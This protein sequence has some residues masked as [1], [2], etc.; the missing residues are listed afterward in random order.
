M[1]DEERYEEEQ[2]RQEDYEDERAE[3][4]REGHDS[5]FPRPKKSESLYSLFQ[6]V[7][8]TD[9][10]SKVAFIDGSELGSL[11]ISVR[12]CQRIAFIAQTLGHPVFANFFAQQ[13]EIILST[14]CSKKGWFAELFVTQKKL[15]ARSYT[16]TQRFEQPQADGGQKWGGKRRKP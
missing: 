9:D 13:A 4:R 1:D 12:D 10:S 8:A 14:S 16:Q 5:E 7:L 11:N 6:D 2:D 15:A 3:M